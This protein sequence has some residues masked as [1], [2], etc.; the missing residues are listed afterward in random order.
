MTKALNGERPLAKQAGGITFMIKRCPYCN[1]PWVV[2]N[3][4]L[5]FGGDMR[6]Y[7]RANPHM[8]IQDLKNS[9]WAH[10]CWTCGN[11]I[12][13]PYKVL[14]GMP[15]WILKLYAKKISDIWKID[16]TKAERRKALDTLNESEH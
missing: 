2:W 10:E 12:Q 5:A 7:I 1:S 3:W 6:A 4:V 13:T 15:H 16:M 14:N 9:R 11:V 8:D